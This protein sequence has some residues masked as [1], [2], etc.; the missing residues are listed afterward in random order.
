MNVDK[1]DTKIAAILLPINTVVNA[2]SN[3]S[4]TLITNLAGLLPSSALICILNLLQQDNAVSLAE[5]KNEKITQRI[6]KT[7][8]I[9]SGISIV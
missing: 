2:L 7:H 5:K 6:I 4:S 8:D 1:V 3:L 9:G